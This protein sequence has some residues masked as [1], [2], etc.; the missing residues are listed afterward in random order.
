VKSFPGDG[1]ARQLLRALTQDSP[2]WGRRR[3]GPKGHVRL[4][5]PFHV[6]EAIFSEKSSSHEL[7]RRT[8]ERLF[9]A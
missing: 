2:P 3:E 7:A 5:P 6:L 8:L 1:S 4:A 9:L